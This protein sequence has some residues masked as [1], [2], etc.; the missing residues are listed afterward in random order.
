MALFKL[1]LAVIGG[2]ALIVMAV[3][4]ASVAQQHEGVQV[5]SSKMTVGA[6][7]HLTTPPS[8]PVTP[9]AK[10]AIKGPAPL[11]SEEEAAK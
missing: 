7:T 9:M 5:A 11:P 10:P 2:S 3:V 6:T 8:V 1:A 4:G